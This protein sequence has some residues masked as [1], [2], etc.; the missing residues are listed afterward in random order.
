MRNTTNPIATLIDAR[1]CQVLSALQSL[2]GRS[3]DQVLNQQLETS[4]SLASC[5]LSRESVDVAAVYFVGWLKIVASQHGLDEADVLAEGEALNNYLES[6]RMLD[7]GCSELTHF[8]DLVQKALTFGSQQRITVVFAGDCL[9]WDSALQLQIVAAAQGIEIKPVVLAQ[10]LSIDLQARVTSLGDKVDLVFY[11][12]YSY[13]F[14]SEYAYASRGWS[15]LAHRQK[16]CAGL[17]RSIQEVRSNLSFMSGKL[18]CP[19]YVHDVSGVAQLSRGLRGIAQHF[20]TL[21]ARQGAS[22]YLNRALAQIVSEVVARAE[23]PILILDESSL[24]NSKERINLG[25]VDF[26]AG[27]LHPTRLA[28]EIASRKYYPALL[29]KVQLASKKIVV[30]DLDN[31]LWRGV[32]GDGPVD[33]YNDRQ[34]ILLRLKA[35]GIV[36]AVSSKNDTQKVSWGGSLLSETDFVARAIDW[37]LKVDNIRKISRQLNLPLAGFVFLDDREDE[38]FLVSDGAPEVLTLDPDEAATWKLLE[39]WCEQLPLAEVADRTLLYQ[40][41]SERQDYIQN[42]PE[43]S[44]KATTLRTLELKLSIR[45]CSNKEIARATEL[46]NRTNQFNTT[47]ART[48][49]EELRARQKEGSVMVAQL[50]DRFGDM[51]IV[52]VLVFDSAQDI[53]ISHFVLSCRAFGF[54][55]ED[56]MLNAVK[57]IGLDVRGELARTAVNTACHDVFERNGFVKANGTWVSNGASQPLPEWLLVNNQ[58]RQSV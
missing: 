6:W 36:L 9:V 29:A 48:T 31:T 8:V 40:Q 19:I 49:K 1:Q 25:K 11:S 27:E 20:V 43:K 44:D 38:R 45:Q 2:Y 4:L 21:G 33:P 13:Q 23:S 34:D 51:G 24:V 37:N 39:T 41:R 28:R 52:G 5:M 12:P 54:G 32:I 46:I 57:D 30:C 55:I 15:W 35:K 50:E 16:S 3:D 58:F 10:R 17:S 53:N 26:D 18:S 47:A 7:P 22:N 56:V 14:S 42:E